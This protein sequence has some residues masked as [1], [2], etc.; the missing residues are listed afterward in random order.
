MKILFT[1]CTSKQTS[2]TA[3][4]R[5]RVKRIDDSSIICNSLRKQ[6]YDVIRK[7][8]EIGEDLSEFAMVI[9]GMGI[10]GSMNYS[11]NILSSFYTVSQFP[12]ERVL[13]H[14]EDWRI[15]QNM[16]SYERHLIPEKFDKILDKRWS[17]GKEFYRSAIKCQENSKIKSK[18]FEAIR[19]VNNGEFTSLIPAFDWGNKQVVRNIIKADTILNIDLS[20]YVKDNWD[21]DLNPQQQE[22]KNGY[23]LASLADH[24]GWVKKQEFNWP[25]DYFG[26]ASLKAPR[27]DTETDVFNKCGE[28]W[29]ILAPEYPMIDGSGWGRSRFWYAAYNK[30]IIIGSPGDMR[31]LGVPYGNIESLSEDK[32][33][34]YAELQS[35]AIIKHLWTKDI[36]DERISSYINLIMKQ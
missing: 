30:S 17:S 25:T 7:K 23:M 5:A 20:P 1:G 19:D 32:L 3:W 18:I 4:K 13:L 26:T 36:F 14:Y 6:G 22:K 33:K 9:V 34:Q 15:D 28:Y 2:D 16:D 8:V 31:A 29:G 21:I 11:E 35:K 24:S 27:L 10:F 12:K